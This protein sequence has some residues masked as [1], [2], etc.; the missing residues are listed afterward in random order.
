MLVTYLVYL[1]LV[2]LQ[3]L[4]VSVSRLQVALAHFRGRVE[5]HSDDKLA[6]QVT[7]ID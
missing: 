2:H 1:V 6:I 5:G 4:V 3:N 7:L